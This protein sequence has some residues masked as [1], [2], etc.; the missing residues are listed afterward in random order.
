MEFIA[1]IGSFLIK[2]T[3]IV[4]AIGAVIILIVSAGSGAKGGAEGAD[5]DVHIRKLNDLIEHD[6]MTLRAATMPE[7]AYKRLASDRQKEAKQKAKAESKSVAKGDNSDSAQAGSSNKPRVFITE[8][9][10]DI[11]A[12]GVT[13]L[14]RVITTILSVANP[15]DEVVLKL[16][17]PGGSVIG[18][19][20]AASQLDRISKAG[21]TLTVCVDKVAASGGYMMA[22]VADKIIAAPFAML[23][24]IGVIF[25]L[26]NVHKL[27]K[28]ADVEYEQI[29]AGEYKRTLTVFAENTDADRAKTKEDVEEIHELFKHHVRSHRPVVDIAKVATGEVWFGSQAVDL[30]LV[31]ELSTSDEYILNKYPDSDLYHISFKKKKSL[32]E[33]LGFAAGEGASFAIR[34]LLHQIDRMKLR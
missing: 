3:I 9:E 24:S 29:T 21:V 30:K 15:Q 8:F 10:G 23:G 18:Y 20:L 12:S 7:A 25:Q 27:L 19:G 2:A 14:R 6:E 33:K 34:R 22:S 17:S 11:E 26:P 28:K 5:G 1:D 32:A 31:D 4:C 13:S 16:E